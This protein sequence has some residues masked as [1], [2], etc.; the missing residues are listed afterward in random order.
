M[1]DIEL[2]GGAA[3]KR[4]FLKGVSEEDRD[5]DIEEILV[6]LDSYI[7]ALVQ[8]MARSSSNI[9]RP[10]VLDLEIDEITQRVR[11]KFW[12]A[13]EAKKIEHHRAYIRTIVSNEFHDLGRK[14]KAPLPLPTDEDGELY[15]GKV[16]L[17]ESEGLA[18]PAIEFGNEEA[19]DELIELTA[20]VVT[21]LPPRMQ[22]SMICHLKEQV[23]AGIRLIE[24]FEKHKININAYRWPDD[25]ADTKRLKAS[26]SPARSII[27]RRV[28]L[29]LQVYKKWGIPDSVTQYY[30]IGKC[31]TCC[32]SSS[33]RDVRRASSRFMA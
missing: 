1:T 5:P 13:L 11:I 33:S 8:K 32:L 16:L 26:L 9:A 2:P 28:G 30:T 17:S 23:D 10:E 25:K 21:D 6:Q 14:R 31:S 22:R 24:A 7:V 27:A 18:D 19:M 20:H 12:M 29:N 4:V 3:M 15:M